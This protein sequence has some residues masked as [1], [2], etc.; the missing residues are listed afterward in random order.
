[1]VNYQH[2]KIYRLVCNVTG[3]QYISSTTQPLSRRLAEHVSKFK[4]WKTGKTKYVTSFKVF[5]GDDYEIILVE[6]FPCE[7]K[8][9]LHARERRWIESLPNVNHHIPTRTKKEWVEANKELIVEYKRQHYVAHKD[10][11]LEKQRRYYETHKEHVAEY[12]QQYRESNKE[13]MRAH[14]QKPIECECGST[15]RRSDIAR[16]KRSAKHQAWE[17]LNQSS[18]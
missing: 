1:M 5:E 12:A 7:N 18:T 14:A 15:V 4:A 3:L 13:Q 16:H 11:L 8:D 9:Q 10:Y 6:G 2:G 17:K